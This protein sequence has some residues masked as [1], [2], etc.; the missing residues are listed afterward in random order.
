MDQIVTSAWFAVIVALLGA[1]ASIILALISFNSK[2]NSRRKDELR[3]FME[4][5]SR[6]AWFTKNSELRDDEIETVKGIERSALLFLEETDVSGSRTLE[7][8][9]YKLSRELFKAR[10][11]I[12]QKG[13]RLL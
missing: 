2:K 7:S 8:A 5:Y 11:L 6:L 3:A 13:S 1:A 12:E 4:L 10:R 9:A